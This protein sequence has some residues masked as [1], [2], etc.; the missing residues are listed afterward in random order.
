MSHLALKEILWID[1]RDSMIRSVVLS[2][3]IH[4]HYGKY[5]R[6]RLAYHEQSS[7]VPPECFP[8][9][10]LQYPI[11][12]IRFC[13]YFPSRQKNRWRELVLALL[14]YLFRKYLW[15]SLQRHQIRKSPS[16]HRALRVQ[17][18]LELLSQNM[19]TSPHFPWDAR[20]YMSSA[21]KHRL[22]SD[23]PEGASRTSS[24]RYR[25]RRRHPVHS[26]FISLVKYH[27]FQIYHIPSDAE[28]YISP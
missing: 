22:F 27:H 28:R 12:S 25:P 1:T 18:S 2:R 9:L 16:H 17:Y 8:F 21:Q 20:S 24:T 4:D 7:R 5:W 11:L 3:K 19:V 15:S 10:S 6:S 14:A 23:P 13:L 26:Q